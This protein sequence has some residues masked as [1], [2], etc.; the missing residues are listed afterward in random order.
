MNLALDYNFVT[1]L[2]SLLVVE[3]SILLNI[4]RE[5]ITSQPSDISNIEDEVESA[6]SFSGLFNLKL[7]V[8]AGIPTTSSLDN[9]SADE[10][11]ESS[12]GPSICIGY[13]VIYLVLLLWMFNLFLMF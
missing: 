13:G 1:E 3:E 6:D 2:T 8:P 7:P 12:S 9:Q 10:E 11:E 5:N 4:S